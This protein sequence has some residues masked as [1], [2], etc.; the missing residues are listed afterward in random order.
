MS[1]E[2]ED[3]RDVALGPDLQT[4]EGEA[5]VSIPPK[6]AVEELDDFAEYNSRSSRE[7]LVGLVEYIGAIGILS[8][9]TLTTGLTSPPDWS[10]IWR[11]C[12]R[13]GVRSLAI[14]CLILFF[15]GMVMSLQF[16]I[17]MKAI[18]ALPYVGKVTSLSIARELAPV[19]TSL[20]VG[21]RVG[22]GIAAEIGSMRVT[23]QIDAIRA[24]GANPVRKLIWPR[25]LAATL[26]IPLVSMMATLV[27]WFGG[28]FLAYLRFDLSMTQYYQSSLATVYLM[29]FIS[30]FIK[31]FF[32]GFFIAIIGCHH[33]LTCGAGTEGV[34]KATTRT[35]VNIAIMTVVVDFILSQV[36]T[37]LPRL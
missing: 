18:G 31:P 16:G 22:A 29:D 35:V 25:V 23:E 15:V 27:G 6:A 5:L 4:T 3:A 28:M 34:G 20:V 14:A 32:F 21:G 8:C 7:M 10:A 30:G 17:T 2:R 19:F 33:G 37:L 11:Q 24:L 13:I 12:E 36:F 9:R 26:T 1:T